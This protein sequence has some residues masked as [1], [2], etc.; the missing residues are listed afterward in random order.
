MEAQF[1]YVSNNFINLYSKEN[2]ILNEQDICYFL[3]TNIADT[4]RPLIGKGIIVRDSFTD[5]YNKNYDI[6]LVEVC[7]TPNIVEE[8][9]LGKTFELYAT[10]ANTTKYGKKFVINSQEILVNNLFRIEAFFVRDSLNK[11]AELRAQYISI[12]KKDLLKQISDIDTI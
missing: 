5:G 1:G 2:P 7:E 6:S 12:I 4:H 3:F 11:I 9:F 8:F 10:T